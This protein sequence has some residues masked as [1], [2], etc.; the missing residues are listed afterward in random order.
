MA[1]AASAGSE[2]AAAASA[3]LETAEASEG[4]EMV[5]AAGWAWAGSA[6]AAAATAACRSPGRRSSWDT[7]NTVCP[8]PDSGT[9][10]TCSC[11][12]RLRIWMV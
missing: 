1:E 11:R 5:A 7:R 8:M 6:E 3:G 10:C 12:D 2:M 4:W 9:P